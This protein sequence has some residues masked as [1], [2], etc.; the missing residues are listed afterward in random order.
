MGMWDGVHSGHRFL[1]DH[2]RALAAERS[3]VPSVV[4]FRA[5]PLTIVRPEA[6]P[7]LLTDLSTRLALLDA[8]GAADCVL[9]DFDARMRRL[10]AAEFLRMLKEDYGVDTLVV[11]F[12][13][14][15]GHDRLEGLEA[16]RTIGAAIGMEVLPAPEFRHRRRP[17]SS[18]KVRA[19]IAGGYVKKAADL[20]G[21][22]F[23]LTGTVV[24]GRQLGRT[25]GFPTANI[26][27]APGMLLPA[28]GAY[29]CIA[30]TPDGVRR[31]A[32]VNIGRRPTVDLPDAPLSIEA[33]ILDFAG[34]IYGCPLT[35][36]FVSRLRDERAFDG[37]E[38][39]RRQ[40]GRDASATRRATRA[41]L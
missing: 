28:A 39:L 3:L 33:H 4:T 5:H 26:S 31:P 18:S 24:S 40:L 10:P 21:R 1:I 41:L 17:V 11:G 32:M 13:N 12:N 14:R 20:L 8:A 6:V 7:P 38:A 16:Y 15:F 22:R 35:L 23:T 34:T 9:L 2:V 27:V 25:I 37:V 36:E 30:L 29:A 19:L